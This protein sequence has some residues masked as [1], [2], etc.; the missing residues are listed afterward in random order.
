M[1]YLRSIHISDVRNTTQQKVEHSHVLCISKLLP[2]QPERFLYC[3]SSV[4][5]AS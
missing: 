3:D 4:N 1:I 2:Q 5:I